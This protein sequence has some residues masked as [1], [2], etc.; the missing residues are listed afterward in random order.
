MAA[1]NDED[2]AKDPARRSG[3]DG[4]PEGPGGV[5]RDTVAC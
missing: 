1:T 5:D 2:A 4:S 3:V